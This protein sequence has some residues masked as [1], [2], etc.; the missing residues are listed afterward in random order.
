MANHSHTQS[1]DQTLNEAGRHG[2]LHCTELRSPKQMDV[3]ALPMRLLIQDTHLLCEHI[4]EVLAILDSTPHSLRN[5][6]KGR[7]QEVEHIQRRRPSPWCS[8]GALGSGQCI[9]ACDAG[10]YPSV[11]SFL[12]DRNSM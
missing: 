12:R 4:V 10:L 1:R 9:P 2:R 3:L 5:I 6:R 8:I 7:E 11:T